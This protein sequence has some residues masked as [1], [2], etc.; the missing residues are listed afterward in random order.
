MSGEANWDMLVVGGT[1]LTMEPDTEPIKN[2]AV[3][4]ADGRIAAVGPA[5]ELLEVGQ[6]GDVLNAGNC[7]VL[8]GLV[9]T[10][11]H[12]AMTLLRGIADDL[13]LMQWLEGHIWPAE[14]EH[15]NRE[16]V[17]LGTELAAAEQLLGG[18]TTTTDMYFFADEVS[19]VLAAAGMRAV[20]AESLIG[21]ATPRC[22]TSEEMLAKQRDLLEAYE[23]HPLITPSVAAH[24]PYSV[25]AA[26]LVAETELA[27]GYEVPMQIHL[28]ETAWEVEKLLEEKGLSPVAY[29]AD[30][31]VLSERTVAAHCVHVSPQDIELLAEFEAGVSH[32]PV[33]NLKLASGVSPVPALLDGGVKLG[34]GTDGA[35]SNNTL[36]LLRDMQLAALLHKGVSG[37]PT[38]LPARQMLE[39]VTVNGARVLGLDKRIGTLVEGHDADL[40]CL[41]I[42]GPH[43]A[44]MYDPFSHVVFAARASDVRH[45]LVRGKILVRNRELKTLDRERIEAQVREFSETVRPS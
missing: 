26:D 6:P 18:I 38:V 27:E 37:D 21:F 32:N 23:D 15:I 42:D 14:K 40:I 17:R 34:L 10:H 36:D 2:G 44:P 20:V 25:Q 5:E 30:L 11:S 39:V 41:S 1:V 12:L 35:A 33:S 4:V 3:A 8:P 7:L 31:G 43:T 13:P 16:T 22:A 19:E 24:A 9:N 45:V 29:L 28:S